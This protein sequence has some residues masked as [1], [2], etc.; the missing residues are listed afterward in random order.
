MAVTRIELR[1]ERE[2]ARGLSGASSK[3]ANL[4]EAHQEAGR[5]VRPVAAG[6]TPVRT[7][8]LRASLKNTADAKAAT[9]SAGN[10]A[11]PYARPIHWGW[12]ARNIRRNAFI[13]D[14]IKSSE[15]R[16]I[17]AYKKAVDGLLS[18]IKGA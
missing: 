14:A 8:A 12:P 5:L 15:S 7:G 3:L 11:V 9:V 2:L 4:R 6:R 18:K 13:W 1:G 10:T 16:W 17:Q